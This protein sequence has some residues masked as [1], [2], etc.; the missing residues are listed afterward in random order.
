M[1]SKR[2]PSSQSCH[3]REYMRQARVFSQHCELRLQAALATTSAPGSSSWYRTRTEHIARH[4]CIN[5]CLLYRFSRKPNPK[6]RMKPQQAVLPRSSFCISKGLLLWVA[7]KLHACLTRARF[8]R[9]F[10]LPHRFSATLPCIFQ[11]LQ[12]SR[13]SRV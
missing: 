4:P 6:S 1:G 13:A 2:L 12:F 3:V 11:P 10:L 9:T 7:G 5:R 8:L